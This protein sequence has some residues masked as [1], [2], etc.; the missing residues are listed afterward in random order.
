MARPRSRSTKP[1]EDDRPLL[2]RM[3]PVLKERASAVRDDAAS[4]R[5]AGVP[6]Q[7][8]ARDQHE[9]GAYPESR[10]AE[11]AGIEAGPRDQPE[12]SDRQAAE[13]TRPTTTRFADWSH[14]LFDQA[15]LAEGGQLDDP[16]SFV[17]RLN[18][19]MLTLAGEGPSRIWTPS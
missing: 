13:D 9:P 11:R 10:R 6:G 2:E 16:A 3:Q 7:R 15:T 8:R 14:I 5:F 18:E 19:L 1:A 4:D 17:K 12:P